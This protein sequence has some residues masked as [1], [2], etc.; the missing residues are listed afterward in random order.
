MKLNEEDKSFIRELL[1]DMRPV[2][3]E[4]R[5]MIHEQ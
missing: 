5:S 1:D 2:M 4:L 3:E